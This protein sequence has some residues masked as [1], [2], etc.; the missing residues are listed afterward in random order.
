MRNPL[1]QIVISLM[2]MLS[3]L[4]LKYPQKYRIYKKCT[5]FST[6]F[7]SLKYGQN[8]ITIGSSDD[9]PQYDDFL[10]DRIKNN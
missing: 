3:L 4:P 10:A 8:G 2:G 6:N 1:E 5:N 7:N 9:S